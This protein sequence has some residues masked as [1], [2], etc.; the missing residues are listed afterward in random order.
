MV[1]TNGAGLDRTS[2]LAWHR[3]ECWRWRRQLGYRASERATQQS[4]LCLVRESLPGHQPSSPRRREDVKYSVPAG[5]VVSCSLHIP[6]A[7]GKDEELGGT[8]SRLVSSC[9]LTNQQ[10]CNAIDW[11]TVAAEYQLQ[12]YFS[13]MSFIYPL[14]SSCWM[15]FL[16]IFQRPSA[17]NN[18]FT[19][20]AW[21]KSAQFPPVIFSP[22]PTN[23]PN[24]PTR[25]FQDS[26]GLRV[27]KM[28][29]IKYAHRNPGSIFLLSLTLSILYA[30][31]LGSLQLDG[32]HRL[33]P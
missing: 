10:P 11:Q 20:S 2:P 15:I 25:L 26:I 3:I 9:S 14:A 23:Q 6:T 29:K 16:T 32:T 12:N 24:R 7:S 4:Q 22:L 13:L 18:P 31:S 30:L 17:H 1:K 19:V 33:T 21:L 28:E 5:R 8:S 27:K